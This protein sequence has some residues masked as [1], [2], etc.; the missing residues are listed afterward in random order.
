MS[1]LDKWSAA[2]YMAEEETRLDEW[3]LL[4][5]NQSK[6]FSLGRVTM[7]CLHIC[8]CYMADGALR[9]QSFQ[10]R[11]GGGRLASI[12][13]HRF[14]LG[15]GKTRW[16]IKPRLVEGRVLLPCGIHALF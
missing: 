3:I 15:H 11:S 10:S 12:R 7:P 1:Q 9:F 4:N 8:V 6:R 2:A 13:R 5:S 16:W 14:D